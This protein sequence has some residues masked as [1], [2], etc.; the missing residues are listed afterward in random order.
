MRDGRRPSRSAPLALVGL[1]ALLVLTAPFAATAAPYKIEAGDV[2]EFSVASLP[3]L[4]QR[5]AVDINGDVNFPLLQDI[6]AAGLPLAELRTRVRELISAKPFRQRGSEG[7][8]TLLTIDPDEITISIVEYRPIYITGD[9][10]RP[11]EQ[12]FRPG[13]T[14]RQAV[15]LGGGYDPAQTK[16]G[17]PA[18]QLVDLRGEFQTLSA[19]LLGN[20]ASITRLDAELEDHDNFILAALPGSPINAATQQAVQQREA[21]ELATRLRDYKAEKTFIAQSIGQADKFLSVLDAQQGNEKAGADLDAQDFDRVNTLFAKGAVPIT[22]V[23][24]ARRAMLLSST[25]QL[26]TTVQVSENQIRREG[27]VRSL[28]KLD[29]QRRA[30]LLQELQTASLASLD[31]QARL[32]AVTQKLALLGRSPSADPDAAPTVEIYRAGQPALAVTDD[33]ELQPGDVVKVKVKDQLLD[34]VAVR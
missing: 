22:R 9:V 6:H 28:D 32:R 4:K 3:T 10:G 17:N 11:G 7:R 13:I 20:R 15:A 31:L 23:M 33:T 19:A 29:D 1:A 2:L 12:P 21:D 18:L 34:T 14:I 24:D 25:R 30:G 26:Q 16:L 5:T 8:E 27:L